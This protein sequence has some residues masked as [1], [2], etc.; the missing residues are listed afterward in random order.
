VKPPKQLGTQNSPTVRI[1]SANEVRRLVERP[2]PYTLRSIVKKTQLSNSTIR[3]I[4]DRDLDMRKHMKTNTQALSNKIVDQWVFKGPRLLEWIKIN[5]WKNIVTIVEAWVYMNHVNGHR[6]IY[7]K[8]REKMS[9]QT[10][11]KN[12]RQKHPKGVIFVVG[13]NS[14]RTTL[15]FVPLNTK[16]NSWFYVNKVLK[17]LFERKILKYIPRMFGSRAHLVVLHH[18]SA[19]AH[20]ASATVQ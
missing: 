19:L 10:W 1:K 8:R 20:K 14:G 6:K 7:Y 3:R 9:P 12:C 5:K 17:P 18:D 2:D 16:V 11:T 4:I 13:I 15:R